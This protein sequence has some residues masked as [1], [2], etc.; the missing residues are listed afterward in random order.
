MKIYD[1]HMHS[2]YSPDASN[3]ATFEN[4]IKEAKKENID[5]LIFTDHV[6]FDASASISRMIPDFY[7]IKN[8]LERL[9]EKH[10]MILNM[11]VEIGFQPHM[12]KAYDRLLKTHPFDFVIM[13]IHQ[14][15]KK[16]FYNGDFFNDKN[17]EEAYTR[18]FTLLKEAIKHYQNYDVIGHIDYII[19]YGDYQRKDYDF[20]RYQPIID[21]IL[22]LIIYYNKGIELNTSGL[23]YGLKH[24]H[25]KKALLKRYKELGGKIITIGSDAHD[26]RDYRKDFDKAFDILKSVGFKKIAVFNKRQARFISIEHLK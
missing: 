13:S 17:Q 4:Y 12:K 20:K 6:D 2:I 1:Q 14:G 25:P 16:D 23:R 8:D 19:R 11:G 3:T 21:E 7:R 15:D 18:Y 22:R 10:R 24:M 9:E 5:T 26:P